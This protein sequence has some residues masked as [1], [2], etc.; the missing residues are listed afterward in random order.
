[1]IMRNKRAVFCKRCGQEVTDNDQFCAGCGLNLVEAETQR[2]TLNDA[3]AK[4]SNARQQ[5][6]VFLLLFVLMV[7]GYLLTHH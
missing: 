6:I 4:R 2:H 5:Q 3:R 7:A 1:M